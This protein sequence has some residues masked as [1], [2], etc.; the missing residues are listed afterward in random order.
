EDSRNSDPSGPTPGQIEIWHASSAN[1]WANSELVL[2]DDAAPARFKHYPVLTIDSTNRSHVVWMEWND[3]GNLYY[4]NSTDWNR[5]IKIKNAST[6][7]GYE[8][9]IT[10]NLI[11]VLKMHQIL[12][13]S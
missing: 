3:N 11:Y 4:A 8:E 5:A 7:I 2:P 9:Q 1:G 12:V 10:L 6:N 13:Y